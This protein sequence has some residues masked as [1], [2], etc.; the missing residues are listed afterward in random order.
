MFV[1]YSFHAT[2]WFISAFRTELDCCGAVYEIERS[3]RFAECPSMTSIACAPFLIYRGG[4]NTSIQCAR[5]EIIVND[6]RPSLY[7][8]VRHTLIVANRFILSHRIWPISLFAC[9]IYNNEIK[10]EHVIM[11]STQF[12]VNAEQFVRFSKFDNFNNPLVN[13]H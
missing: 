4:S 10:C 3:Q 1:V 7:L 11:S 9:I 12:I 5:N 13:L 6:S 8:D 2:M